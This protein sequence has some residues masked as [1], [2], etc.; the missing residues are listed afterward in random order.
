M[1]YAKLTPVFS[2]LREVG[3][4]S[5]YNSADLTLEG[6]WVPDLPR[7]DWQDISAQSEN[8]RYLAVVAWATNDQG[9]PGFRI[10]VIDKKEKNVRVSRRQRGCCRSLSWHGSHGLSWEA[11]CYTPVKGMLQWTRQE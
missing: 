2:N 5:P 9:E 10:V 3:M 1:A 11:Y 7:F 6:N 4:G 8:G